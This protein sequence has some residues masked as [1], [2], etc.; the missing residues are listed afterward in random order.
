VKN[1]LK[2]K[3]AR[4]VVLWLLLAVVVLYIITGFGITEYRIVEYVTFGLLAKP[5]AFMIHDN[6]LIPFIVL[7]ILHIYQGFGKSTKKK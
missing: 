6:L 1:I 4:R 2:L 5:L 7:L 3:P